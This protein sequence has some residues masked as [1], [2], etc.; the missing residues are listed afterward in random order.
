[1]APPGRARFERTLNMTIVETAGEAML[2]AHA[3]EREIAAALA[4]GAHRLGRRIRA[5]LDRSRPSVRTK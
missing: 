2:L 5:W 3:G 1:M 4:T